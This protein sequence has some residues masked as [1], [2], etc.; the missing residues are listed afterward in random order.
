MFAIPELWEIK[1]KIWSIKRG[2]KDK[3]KPVYDAV[4]V[5]MQRPAY[6]LA[7]QN[8]AN[9]SESLCG[10]AYRKNMRVQPQ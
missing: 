4:N 5:C 3:M 6:R 8:L 7:F 10:S 2:Q 1:K 9:A